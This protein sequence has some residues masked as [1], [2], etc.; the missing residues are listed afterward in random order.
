MI[1]LEEAFSFVP[2][3]KWASVSISDKNGKPFRIKD[4]TLIWEMIM[5]SDGAL[6]GIN[7][8][9][10]LLNDLILKQSEYPQYFNYEDKELCRK[11]IEE[12]YKKW[13]HKEHILDCEVFEVGLFSSAYINA[14]MSF[15]NP[16]TRKVGLIHNCR[17]TWESIKTCKEELEW[18]CKNFCKNG[19]EFYVSFFD[20][21]YD[22]DYKNAEDPKITLKLSS[23]GIEV[24][25]IIPKKKMKKLFKGYNK[26]IY[27]K[28][29]RKYNRFS[30]IKKIYRS[31]QKKFDYDM[32]YL[33]H[34][35]DLFGE[36]FG[37]IINLHERYFTVNEILKYIEMWKTYILNCG[38]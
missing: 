28:E 9:N 16:K 20:D 5:K 19:V 8:N 27:G 33:W 11:D 23:N 32:W 15:I 10:T 1:T 17:W 14:P 26:R 12:W 22:E 6:V 29:F 30:F 4:D 18:V 7:G 13:N 35:F 25:D 36:N 21:E 34:E 38:N 31:L 24:S 37:Q 3:G 2:Y